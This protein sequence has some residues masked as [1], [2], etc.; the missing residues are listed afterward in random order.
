VYSKSSAQYF[1]DSAKAASIAATPAV[2]APP[3]Q[4]IFP[5]RKPTL[6]VN[7]AGGY[8]I[9]TCV[10]RT[11]LA[12]ECKVKIK[13]ERITFETDMVKIDHSVFG[14]IRLSEKELIFSS[15]VKNSDKRNTD[16]GQQ[17]LCKHH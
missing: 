14:I 9:K 16:W 17:N 12:S 4:H 15:K 5:V 1:D 10:S 7:S 11:Q 3:S 2:A 8:V 13:P 6:T